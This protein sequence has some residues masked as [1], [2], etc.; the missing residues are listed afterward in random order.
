[1]NSLAYNN[2]KEFSFDW[3]KK[4]VAE[5]KASIN[6]NSVVWKANTGSQGTY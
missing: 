5:G 1:M 2:S 4:Q 3:L 6:G